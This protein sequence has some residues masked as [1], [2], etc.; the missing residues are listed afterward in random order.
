LAVQFDGRSDR[1]GLGVH[2]VE[3]G[4]ELPVNRHAGILRGNPVLTSRVIQYYHSP[5]H[6]RGETMTASTRIHPFE[7]R[8]LGVAPYRCVDVYEKRTNTGQPGGTCDFCGNGIASCYVIVG[9]DGKQFIVGSDCVMRTYA[10]CDTTT[11]V[12]FRRLKAKLD[13][14]KRDAKRQAKWERL[15][16][17]VAVVRAALA[18]DADLFA[19]EPHPHPY[20]ANNGATKRDYFEWILSYGGESGRIAVCRAVETATGGC[21]ALQSE[22]PPCPTPP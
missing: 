1:A 7:E 4:F 10:A 18:A 6:Q 8:G 22:T 17:R 12:E 13:R 20:H 21:V 11:P 5:V 19:H 3:H 2:R 15:M 16:A 9:S 14:E